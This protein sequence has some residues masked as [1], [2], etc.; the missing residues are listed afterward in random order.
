MKILQTA[1]LMGL[2]ILGSPMVAFSQKAY[3]SG[4]YLHLEDSISNYGKID[5]SVYLIGDAGE[6]GNTGLTALDLLKNHIKN[7]GNNSTVVFLGDNVYPKGI[8]AEGEKGR[9]EAESILTGQLEIFNTYDGKVY[10]IPGN[11]DWGQWSKDGWEAIKREEEIVKKHEQG[12]IEFLPS[13]GC[14]GPIKVKLEKDVLLL[15]I[16]TQW[17]LHEWEKPYGEDCDCEVKNEFQFIQEIEKIVSKNLDKQIILVGHHPVFTNGNHGGHFQLKDHLFPLTSLNKALYIPLPVLGSLYP[18]YRKHIG[19]IQDNNNKRYLLFTSELLEAIN[20]HPN[21]IY[22]AGHEHSLQYFNKQNQHFIVSGSGSKAKYVSKRNSAEFTYE[23]QGFSKVNY[24]ESGETWI[25]YWVVSNDN[26]ENGRIVFR[27]KIKEGKSTIDSLTRPQTIVIEASDKMSAGPFKQW[28]LG[29]HHREAWGMPVEVEVLDLGKEGLTPVKLGGGKQTKSLRLENVEGTQFVF[30]SIE[31]NPAKVV[32]PQNMQNTW[33]ADLMRDQVSMSHPYGAFVIPT[34]AEAT[35]ILHK[36]S[37]LVYIPDD[38][39]LGA[40]RDVYKN[41]LASYEVRANKNIED[42]DG[43]GSAK[44][45]ISTPD[46]IQ[47]LHDDNDNV[48]DEEDMLRNRLFDMLVGDFDRH[49]DQW[50]WAEFECKKGNHESCYHEK[51]NA[52]KGLTFRPIPRDRD[53]V[54]DKVDGLVARGMSLKFAPGR[55][56]RDF[57][58]EIHDLIGLNINGRELDKTFLTRLSQK[59]WI[60]IAEEIQKNLTDEI[61]RSAFVVW[62]ESIFA[63]GGEEIVQ[64]LMR[65]RDDLV[66]Y[67]KEYYLL[68]AKEVEIVGSNKDE[69]FEIYRHDNGNTTVKIY[70]K[71]K[72]SEKALTYNRTFVKNETK[73]LFIYGLGG[74]DHFEVYGS[75]SYSAKIRLIGGDGIDMFNDISSVK[76]LS[77]RTLVYDV[78]SGTIVKGGKETKDNTSDKGEQVNEY[79]RFRYKANIVAPILILGYNIDDGLIFGGG[80]TIKNQ[81]WRKTPYASLQ[82]LSVAYATN[83]GAVKFDYSADFK[84]IINKWSLFLDASLM[85]PNNSTNFY[86]LGNETKA[87]DPASEFYQV[88]FDRLKLSALFGNKF[89]KQHQFK[90]G[91]TYEY[92]QI[93][94]TA[95]KFVSSQLAGINAEELRET[96]FMGLNFNY[97]INTIDPIAERKKGV[98]WVINADWLNN[99]S[100]STSLSTVESEFTFIRQFRLPFYPVISSRLGGRTIFGKFNFYQA[101]TLGGQNKEM[102]KGNIRGYHRD[103]YSGRSVVYQN[104]DLRLQLFKIQTYLFPGAAGVLGFVDYGKIWNNDNSNKLHVSYGGGVWLNIMSRITLVAS[105]EESTDGTFFTFRTKYLF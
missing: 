42:V 58:Y 22:A 67:A 66:K 104:T 21:F 3:Y 18:M 71:Y 33:V 75:N 57:D 28:I 97:E 89:S 85:A 44:R 65:R 82:K 6:S 34:L 79:L 55:I 68:L 2:I 16:D 10:Y 83:T 49:D 92:L 17:W 64:K 88:N 69:L 101:S 94:N 78:S 24:L 90:I 86:G 36:K 40:F 51:G 47:L 70:K 25:E 32:L 30:R 43:F 56:L 31:K 7:E 103:R 60:A 50:R 87:A 29:S 99:T 15:I 95:D 63:L 54:F 100:N 14:P 8:P 23:K 73:E 37:K 61:I 76:G 48:V 35:G 5:H 93:I 12:N 77:K 41:T 59:E 105:Y 45:A 84:Q 102:E 74:D 4:E 62:P 27:K 96:G 53:Q 98:N 20:G 38:P 81:G 11:H 72:H 91:P 39:K 19:S 52:T 13:Q 1:C 9:E 80:V 26:P 46:M